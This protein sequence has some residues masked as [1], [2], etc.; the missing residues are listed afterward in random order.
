MNNILDWGLGERDKKIKTLLNQ[1]HD[2]YEAFK[3][4]KATGKDKDKSVDKS[5]GSK[6][7]RMDEVGSG[8]SEIWQA[9]QLSSA[10][11]QGNDII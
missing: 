10:E 4:A 11:D 2:R 9:M 8:G 1:V 6:K 3:A 7:R 5:S